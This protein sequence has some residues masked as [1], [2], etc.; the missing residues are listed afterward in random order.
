MK[1]SQAGIELI[2]RF[3][4]CRLTA[5]KPIPAEQYYTIGY[6]HYGPDVMPG[7]RIT[8]TQAEAILTE[9]LKK[10]EYA[11][12]STL[13]ILNQNQFDALVSFSYNCGIGSLRSLTKRRTVNQIADA[14]LLYNK[15]SGK[16]LPGL[17]RRRQA[18]RA[19]FLSKTVTGINARIRNRRE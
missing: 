7:M 2:K 4:G 1:T 17:A 12:N 9:D 10:Y 13:L 6:G 3:E 11:V 15:G 5:Y 19:L 18:E 16:V 8:Q 14:L